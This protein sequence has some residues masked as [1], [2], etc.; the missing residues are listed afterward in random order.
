MDAN[1]WPWIAIIGF[2]IFCCVPMLFMHKRD[3]HSQPKGE[4]KKPEK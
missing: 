3:S 2:L 4:E 1:W